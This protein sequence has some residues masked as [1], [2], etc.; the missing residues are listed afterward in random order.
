MNRMRRTG[1]GAAGAVVTGSSSSRYSSDKGID[2]SP[3]TSKR[4]RSSSVGMNGR[5]SR[6]NKS[7]E[8]GCRSSR[9]ETRSCKSRIK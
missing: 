5:G 2:S 6:S 4:R 3:E 9:R 1:I 7:H 8:G